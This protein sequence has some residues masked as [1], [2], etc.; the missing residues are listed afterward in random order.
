MRSSNRRRASTTP[1]TAS[2]RFEQMFFT[3]ARHPRARRDVHVA[4]VRV[5]WEQAVVRSA[6]HQRPQLARRVAAIQRRLEADHRL[7]VRHRRPL[8][9]SRTGPAG[10]SS[11]RRTKPN[12]RS[13]GCPS[14][15]ST[16]TQGE[17]GKLVI[18]DRLLL[19]NNLD[20]HSK[21]LSLQDRQTARLLL[22]NQQSA[23]SSRIDAG[24][25]GGVCDPLRTD[26]RNAR[27]LV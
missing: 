5:A 13:S 8:A 10:R 7:P 9:R 15:F 12:G 6:L 2:S 21:H 24:R 22:Q 16:R 27:H 26:A 11:G 4:H 19:G 3:V 18:I 20:Q 14:F 25:R 1:A 17:L 23:L